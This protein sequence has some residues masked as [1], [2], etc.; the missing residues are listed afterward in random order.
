LSSHWVESG[1]SPSTYLFSF[2]ISTVG[3]NICNAVWRGRVLRKFPESC[4]NEDIWSMMKKQ[5]RVTSKLIA[6]RLEPPNLKEL[7]SANNLNELG[8]SP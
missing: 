4:S 8:R 6:H 1:A 7:D 2:P 5:T 3:F